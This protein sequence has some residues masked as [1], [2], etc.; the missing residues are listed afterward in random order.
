MTDSNLGLN[1][2]D[3]KD[4]VVAPCDDVPCAVNESLT[5]DS[6]RPA[7]ADSTARGLGPSRSVR[8]PFFAG[9]FDE[10]VR[11]GRAVGR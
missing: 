10:R 7:C 9:V 4:C 2:R 6:N 11:G 3:N 1:C 8:L 5:G